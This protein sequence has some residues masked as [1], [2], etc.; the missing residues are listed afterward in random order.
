MRSTWFMRVLRA[1]VALAVLA[2]LATQAFAD[3]ARDA[4]RRGFNLRAGP[5]GVMEVNRVLCG[6][7]TMG[8]I[9]TAPAGSPILG[10][11]V[12][13]RGTPDQYIFNSGLQIAGT[14]PANAGFEWAGDT[15]GVFFMDPRGGQGAGTGVTLLFSSL[16][17]GDLTIWPDAGMVRDTALFNDV[18][19]GRSAVSQQDTWVRYW[20]GDPGFFQTGR[21]HPMG[22]LVEQR[23]MAWNFPTGNEDIIYF[24]F[25]FWNITASDAAAYADI[26]PAIRGDIAALGV[27]FQANV[28]SR[29][30]VNIPD[31]GYAFENLFAA[32]FMDPD[33]GDATNNYSTGILP[34]QLGIAYVSTFDQESFAFPADVF[35]APF[36]P[37]PG[38]VGVKYLKSPIDPAT[39]E[40]VGLT[41]FSNTLNQATGFPDPIGVLQMW[42]YLSGN[43]SPAAGDNPCTFPN[44]RQR[45]LC[46]LFQDPTDTRFYQSSGPFVLEPG[47]AATIVVAYIHAAPV[48]AALLDAG[49]AGTDVKP[50]IAFPGDSLFLDPGKVRD[51]ERIAGWL[52]A[53]DTNMSGAIEQFEVESVPRSLL[54]KA[55]VAQAVFDNKFLLPFAPDA[56]QFFLVPGDNQVTVVWT[57]SASETAGDPF[58]D[59]ASNPASPLFDPNFRRLDVE[60][61]RIYRGRTPAQLELVAQ[62][63]YAG[64]TFTDFTGGFDYGNQC[65]PELGVSTVDGDNQG[66]A[67]GCPVDFSA[68]ASNTLGIVD[69]LIQVPPGG[70]VELA[71]GSV[72][73][74]SADTSVVG[75]G[76][77]RPSDTGVPFAFID[78]G[79]RNSFNY[80]YAVTAFDVNSVVS[81]PTSL[82]SARVTRSVVPRASSPNQLLA[83]LSF[84]VFGGGDEPLDPTPE[85][86]IDAATGRFTGPPPPT[87][88]TQLAAA[89]A[90][91][92]PQL[93]PALNLEFVIDSVRGIDGGDRADCRAD[94]QNIQ[95]ICG[96]F[97][98]TF[99]RDATSQS[100]STVVAWPIWEAFGG[101]DASIP[102]SGLGAFP[103]TADADA[104]ARFGLPAGFA[105]FNASV[106]ATFN[107]YIRYSAHEGQQSR[108]LR[109]IAG[110]TGAS[111]GGSR[112]FEGADETL[113][114]PAYGMRAGHLDGVD[115]IYAPLSHIDIDPTT[116]GPQDYLPDFGDAGGN[117]IR[118]VMQC[119]AYA[120][121]MLGRQ[122]DIQVTWGPG[123]TI[124]SVFDVTHAL[125]VPFRTVPDGSYGFFG[126]FNGNGKIDW[127]DFDRVENVAQAIANLGFCAGTDPGP[128]NRSELVQNPVIMAT[129][130]AGTG[131]MGDLASMPTTGTGFGI[132]I[133][134]Q[135]F[136]FELDGG[137]PPPDG[138]TWTLRSYAGTVNADAA[139]RAT[140]APTNY[141]YTP[142]PGSPAIPGLRV[143]FSVEESTRLTASAERDLDR[144]HTV[145]DPYYV[146]NALEQTANTKILRFINLPPRAIIRIYSLSGVLVNVV[147]HNDPGFGSEVTWNLRNRN[148][149]FVASGVYFYHVETPEGFEKVGRFTVV[150][151][152]Q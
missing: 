142:I 36:A 133:N 21:I 108:R 55:I 43:V 118:T 74:I 83:E 60:G 116:D 27:E 77:P 127:R 34:F 87:A 80:H 2:V 61:Y 152:A 84:A 75:S 121:A 85:W 145:P 100:F 88:A 115:S 99:N 9:C 130:N 144:V 76:F 22:V 68:G 103:V 64:T 20:D 81:G 65:A 78:T 136:I 57:Q 92:V 123:G 132:Y 82:E 86:T 69:S 105:Q 139:T 45:Q 8:Q 63:D 125:D 51:I 89:F 124:A 10:G 44:P 23:G 102:T 149:Q 53:A 11:G 107:R 17:P 6:L 97:F 117:T 131:T 71:D 150:N 141:T 73:I 47:G 72:L 111:P 54:D 119:Y 38:F 109:T 148:N 7:D 39:E 5:F 120:I 140:T 32:F 126:D 66:D 29:L 110:S 42:R 16:D 90:P 138:T 151:F 24:I 101:V 95:G 91:L 70:R 14:I 129:S 94:I 52:T 28:Q 26:D 48:A 128:G 40:E 98:V 143:V 50:E 135:I 13:P 18:L 113:D 19:I 41:L 25:T 4:R 37:A 33:V 12:W 15:T 104:A 46:F 31:G 1:G 147:E 114:H 96:E 59:V 3:V 106:A 56:P 112:W 49:G 67:D 93:L 122:A 35:G 79:V 134:G 30:G 58:F 62:F 146:T 137:T